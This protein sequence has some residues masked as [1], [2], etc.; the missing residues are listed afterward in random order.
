MSLNI[1]VVNLQKGKIIAPMVWLNHA[2]LRSLLL[3]YIAHHKVDS[4]A[5]LS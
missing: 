2:G 3:I 1:N 4:E 5:K